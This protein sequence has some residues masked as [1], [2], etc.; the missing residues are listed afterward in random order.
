M[1]ISKQAL[2]KR[3]EESYIEL[4]VSE[5]NQEK[6][7]TFL[8]IIELKDIPTYTHSMRV[9]ILALEI[10][11]ALEKNPKPLFFSGLIHDIGKIGIDNDL[12][13]K[14]DNFNHKDMEQMK[15]HVMIGYRI[16][17]KINPFSAEIVI[18]HHYYKQKDPY[19]SW[20]EL[21]SRQP[22]IPLSAIQKASSYALLLAIADVYDAYVTRKN[23][24]LQRI[25]RPEETRKYMIAD[26]PNNSD[27]IDQLYDKGLLGTDYARVLGIEKKQKKNKKIK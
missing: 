14:T 2:E 1:G 15:A 8:K 12:L 16:L 17:K 24:Q 19:P 3:I 21:A 6:L 27:I 20:E 18:L 11:K 25:I 4:R 9:G 13:N 7:N 10:G 23:I 22:H 26:Y 5:K